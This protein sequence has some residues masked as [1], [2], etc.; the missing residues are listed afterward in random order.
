MVPKQCVNPQQKSPAQP[1]FLGVFFSNL[2]GE[3]MTCC[4][5]NEM[6]RDTILNR[7]SKLW[8]V[9]LHLDHLGWMKLLEY[10]LRFLSKSDWSDRFVSQ[11]A[12]GNISSGHQVWMTTRFDAPSIVSNIDNP[13]IYSVCPSCIRYIQKWFT[14]QCYQTWQENYINMT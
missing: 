2:L 11:L 3:G 4:S 14:L 6:G 8:L 10:V 9:L 13:N 5:L 12:M 1:W 7:R